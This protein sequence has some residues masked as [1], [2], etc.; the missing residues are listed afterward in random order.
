MSYIMQYC[1]QSLVD[2]DCI[3]ISVTLISTNFIQ[4]GKCSALHSKEV[5]ISTLWGHTQFMSS[6]K[7]YNT[8]YGGP[9]NPMFFVNQRLYALE[10]PL[11]S[12]NAK[13]FKE[14]NYYKIIRWT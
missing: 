8:V 12:Q 2:L 9:F 10:T 1:I 3:Y 14:I 4:M 11:K 6:Y 7:L 5:F 13:Y